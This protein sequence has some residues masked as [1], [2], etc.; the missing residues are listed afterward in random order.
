MFFLGLNCCFEVRSFFEYLCKK[1]VFFYDNFMLINGVYLENFMVL[2]ILIIGIEKFK[3]L[4]V[5][6]FFIC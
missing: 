5:F 2:I 4:W 6:F 3:Y 1:Y